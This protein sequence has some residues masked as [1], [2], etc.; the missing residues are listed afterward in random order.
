MNKELSNS[1][2]LLISFDPTFLHYSSL[3]LLEIMYK[4][5]FKEKGRIFTYI[6]AQCE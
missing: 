6:C 1:R 3:S 4:R 2:L 5:K